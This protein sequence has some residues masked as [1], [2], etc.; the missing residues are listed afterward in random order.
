MNGF[1]RRYVAV[2]V[3]AAAQNDPRMGVFYDALLAASLRD[4]GADL[5]DA[6]LHFQFVERGGRDGWWGLLDSVEQASSPKF[7]AWLRF[8]SSLA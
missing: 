7:A 3:K 5:L 1:L 4:Y 2:S 8:V 6:W